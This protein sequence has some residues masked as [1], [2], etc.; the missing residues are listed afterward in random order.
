MFPIGSLDSWNYLLKKLRVSLQEE[1]F[2]LKG[3]LI[4]NQ[5]KLEITIPK[6][7][8]KKPE[9]DTPINFQNLTLSNNQNKKQNSILNTKI[10]FVKN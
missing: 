6:L 10:N 4:W 8:T 7:N 3:N 5:G 1:N 2:K 9:I